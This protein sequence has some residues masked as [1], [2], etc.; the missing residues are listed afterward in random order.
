MVNNGIWITYWLTRIDAFKDMLV[1]VTSVSFVATFAT[2]MFTLVDADCSRKEFKV[3]LISKVFIGVGIT[4]MVLNSF[5][6]SKSDLA[7]I[8]GAGLGAHAY[9]EV[10]TSP[11]TK[12]A[13]ELLGLTIKEA[14][15]KAKKKIDK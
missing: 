11:I 7:L 1:S 9:E 13:Q 5:I 8:V 4:T 6:P 14:L 3:K 10:S 2:L 12:D 15:E